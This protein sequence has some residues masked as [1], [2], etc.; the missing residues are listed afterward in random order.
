MT[1]SRTS[2][3][4]PDELFLSGR[5]QLDTA[6]TVLEVTGINPK[7]EEGLRALRTLH[8]L[9]TT[10]ESQN[11]LKYYAE[12]GTTRKMKADIVTS[13]LMVGRIQG[14]E[15]ELRLSASWLISVLTGNTN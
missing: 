3:H 10:T 8:E 9:A 4:D 11:D 7:A 2:Q 1:E 12:G 14:L 6:I 15:P 5:L 13:A